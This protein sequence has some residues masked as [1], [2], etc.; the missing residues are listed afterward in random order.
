MDTTITILYFKS[1]ICL[2][3]AGARSIIYM[4]F[5]AEINFLYSKNRHKGHKIV[6]VVSI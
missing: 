5:F 3:R 6:I 4:R 2:M 1:T